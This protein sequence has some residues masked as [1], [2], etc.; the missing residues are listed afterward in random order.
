MV[1]EVYSSNLHSLVLGIIL[2][3]MLLLLEF[4]A[5]KTLLYPLKPEDRITIPVLYQ[6]PI[7]I[8]FILTREVIRNYIHREKF[9]LYYCDFNDD[10]NINY[11][12]NNYCIYMIDKIEIL[13]VGNNDTRKF[14]LWLFDSK[15]QSL[16]EIRSKIFELKEEN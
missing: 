11:I 2:I 15:Y 4:V 12:E 9:N 10:I 8:C 14:N 16:S 3:V 7:I 5:I 6:I 13:F 1:K